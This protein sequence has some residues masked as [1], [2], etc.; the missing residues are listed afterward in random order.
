MRLR[1]PW[2]DAELEP[3]LVVRQTLRDQFDDLALSVG[4]A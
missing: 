4:N 3:D 2:R 1:R